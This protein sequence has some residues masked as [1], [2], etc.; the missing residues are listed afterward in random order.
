[1][2]DVGKYSLLTGFNT[3]INHAQSVL[4]VQRNS[5]DRN[6]VNGA[7]WEWYT[8]A[9]LV[10]FQA[11]I[12]IPCSWNSARYIRGFRPAPAGC[13]SVRNFFNVRKIQWKS[14]PAGLLI[15]LTA[16]SLSFFAREWNLFHDKIHERDDR[17]FLGIASYFSHWFKIRL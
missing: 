4:H 8:R 9:P 6:G 2:R 10:L 7:S 1:M 12:V 14:F 5:T 3:C 16:E 15:L 13:G 17:D 11:S